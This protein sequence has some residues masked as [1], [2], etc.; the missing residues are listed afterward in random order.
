M[1]VEIDGAGWHPTTA[2]VWL[3]ALLAGIPALLAIQR[4][5]L[6]PPCR[7]PRRRGWLGIELGCG[8]GGSDGG[9]CSD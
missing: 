6:N 1:Q 4:A 9:D 7:E 8:D 5:F 3:L 2:G